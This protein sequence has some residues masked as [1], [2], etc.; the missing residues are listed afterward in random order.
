MLVRPPGMDT[1]R[2]EGIPSSLNKTRSACRRG[3]YLKRISATKVTEAP[4]LLV[5]TTMGPVA[6]SFVSL[7]HKFNSLGDLTTAVVDF[8]SAKLN[9]GLPSQYYLTQFRL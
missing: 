6:E 2:K 5:E 3:S 1:S 8:L 7:G 9:R 4:D